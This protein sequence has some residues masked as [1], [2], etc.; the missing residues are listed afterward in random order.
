MKKLL[1]TLIGSFTLTASL[2]ALAG[3]DWQLID[4]ARK[5][6]QASAM[7]RQGDS[8]SGS[9]TSGARGAK[10]PV[11]ALVLPLDHG[12]RAQTTPAQNQLRKERHEAAQKAC[13]GLTK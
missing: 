8:V 10:C 6:K 9:G 11:E 1:I 5:N 13:E 2:P 7:A 3:P 12:P 4:K